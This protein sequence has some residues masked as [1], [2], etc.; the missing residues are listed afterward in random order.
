M[1]S[2]FNGGMLVLWYA[3]AEIMALIR[4]RRP[5]PG[6]LGRGARHRRHAGRR[7]LRPAGRARHD[8]ALGQ[9][10]GVPLEHAAAQRAGV[11]RPDD[12][13]R[14]AARGRGRVPAAVASRR[15]RRSSRS[16]C[17]PAICL[18]ILMF[19]EL[20]YHPNTYVP[21]RAFH[22]LYLVCAVWMAFAV[23][24]W[25]AWRRPA[26]LAMWAAM[27][28]PRR[29]SRCRRSRSTGT[30]RATSATST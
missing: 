15:R 6:T 2:S 27:G 7:R 1:C 29:C 10:G 25:Q 28:D 9:R 30:T 14:G 11:A 23:D 17:S 5:R 13:R 20:K 26:R 12:A 18:L 16:P 19:V 22:M 24:A 21:F 8:P 3:G 4:R